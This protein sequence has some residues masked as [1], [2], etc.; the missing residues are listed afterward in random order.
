MAPDKFLRP[1]IDLIMCGYPGATFHLDIRQGI[2]KPVWEYYVTLLPQ[3]DVQHVVH[4]QDGRDLEIAP[5]NRTKTYPAQQPSQPGSQ[6]SGKDFGET[7]RGPLGWIVHARSGDKGSNANVGF[8]VRHK[9]EYDWMRAVLS[10]E[11]MK[12]LLAKEYSGNKIVSYT[13]VLGF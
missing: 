6:V 10:V 7:V 5:P 9:D 8:W 2:P 13:D 12:G 4:M 11:N 3:S 1:V